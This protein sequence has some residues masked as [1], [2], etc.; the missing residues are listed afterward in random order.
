[1][2]EIG[3]VINHTTATSIVQIYNGDNYVGLSVG[4]IQITIETVIIPLY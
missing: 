3:S 2:R 4:V 1:M